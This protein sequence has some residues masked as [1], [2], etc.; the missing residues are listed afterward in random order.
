MNALGSVTHVAASA[1]GWMI[2]VQ[3]PRI[4]KRKGILSHDLSRG[5]EHVRIPV[6]NEIDDTRLPALT[7]IR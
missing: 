6:I 5:V 7:Y 1:Q 4:E 2:L 3:V